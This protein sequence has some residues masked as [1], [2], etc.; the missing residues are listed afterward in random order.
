MAGNQAVARK[1]RMSGFARTISKISKKSMSLFVPVVR[2][3]IIPAMLYF[4][5][6]HTEPAPSLMELVN[7]LF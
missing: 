7:P 2:Y 5:M 3:S 6:Y 4:T 1:A